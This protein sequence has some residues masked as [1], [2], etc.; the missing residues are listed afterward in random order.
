MDNAQALKVLFEIKKILDRLNIPFFLQY[1]TCLGIYRDGDFLP[2][3]DDIDIGVIGFERFEE[4]RDEFE[5]CGFKRRWQG[6]VNH[7]YLAREKYGIPIDVLFYVET[8]KNYQCWVKDG[9]PYLFFPKRFNTFEKI[10]FKEVDFNVL[11]PIREYLE[12]CYGD[13]RNKENKVSAAYNW[14]TK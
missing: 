10:R 9:D 11:H 1:G 7:R 3:D 5:K 4:V 2:G 13:W 8:D 12:W 14:T 6:K